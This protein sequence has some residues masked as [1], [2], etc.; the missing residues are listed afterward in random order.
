MLDGR[1]SIALPTLRRVETGID[2]LEF[3]EH[4][5]NVEG[6]PEPA[7]G[8]IRLTCA[9]R[10]PGAAHREFRDDCV[11]VG[12]IATGLG[13]VPGFLKEGT[14]ERAF[15]LHFAERRAG[16]PS[17]QAPKRLKSSLSRPSSM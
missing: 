9:A 5:R 1:L 2:V 12:S 4:L 8:E 15:G 16:I 7:Q 10:R 17:A 3:A 6:A 14:N 11:A 13:V